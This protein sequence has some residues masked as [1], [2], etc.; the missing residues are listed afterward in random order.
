MENP[1]SS[2]SE[3]IKKIYAHY[4]EGNLSA[5][6]RQI[7]VAAQ[8]VRD[9]MKGNKGGPS[10]PVLQNILQA[11]PAI[12]LDWMLRGEGEMLKTSPQNAQVQNSSSYKPPKPRT[13]TVQPGLAAGLVSELPTEEKPGYGDIN[14]QVGSRKK[15][16]PA[17]TDLIEQV[18][19]NTADIQQLFDLLRN[20]TSVDPKAADSSTPGPADAGH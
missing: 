3:R 12:N 19:Q 4:G 17:G 11:Y 14:I 6:S 9:L 16:R 13:G 1:Q 20:G 7:G 15:Q 5:F 10:W 18:A 8:T 2:V